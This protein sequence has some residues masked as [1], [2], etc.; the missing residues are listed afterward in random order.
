MNKVCMTGRLTKDP[1]FVS[2]DGN[3]GFATFSLAVNRPNTKNDVVDFFNCTIWK[4]KANYVMQY[5]KKGDLVAITGVLQ[6]RSYEEKSTHEKRIVVEIYV[7]QLDQMTFARKENNDNSN[8]SDTFKVRSDE[9]Y[10]PN[11]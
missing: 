11:W 2:F 6:T 8:T 4:E 7:E 10:T 1:T 5:V 3:S 9:E